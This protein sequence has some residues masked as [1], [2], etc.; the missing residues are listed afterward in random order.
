MEGR[1]KGEDINLEEEVEAQGNVW[2]HTFSFITS[3]TLKCA[4]ELGIPDAIHSHGG[5]TPLSELAAMLAIPPRRIAAL[6]R[7]MRT[8]VNSGC[9]AIAK[10]IG[11]GKEDTYVLT[12][13]SRLLLKAKP[14][15]AAPYVL[16]MLDPVVLQTWHSLSAWFHGEERTPF[17]L[18]HG[19]GV[20]E[21][22]RERPELAA[23]LKSAS[24]SDTQL[25]GRV[26]VRECREAFK[27]VKSLVDVGGCTGTMA[28]IIAE[29]FPEIKCTVFDLPH[30]VAAAAAEVEAPA[31]VDFVGGDMFERVPPADVVLLKL[32]LHDW[33]D[34]DCVKILRRCKEAIPSKENGGKLIIVDAVMEGVDAGSNKSTETKLLFDMATMVVAGG[35]QREEK[36]WRKIFFDAGFSDYKINPVLGVRSI[37]E[38]YP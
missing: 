28:M 13:F 20:F 29:A 9:F 24:A 6:R 16:G 37:I 34:D 27:G 5:P 1:T 11:D 4:V 15:S 21:M 14:T 38:V 22:A 30:V 32:I 12:P 18:V 33:S 23:F 19:K 2:N 3:M 7:L 25:V 10:D 31:A 26:I 36:E 8:L 17:R 35:M